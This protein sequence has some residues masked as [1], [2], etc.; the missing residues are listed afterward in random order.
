MSFGRRMGGSE[1]STLRLTMMSTDTLFLLLFILIFST[2]F[3]F[4]CK[5]YITKYGLFVR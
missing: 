2:S 1:R 4:F 5:A 3:F